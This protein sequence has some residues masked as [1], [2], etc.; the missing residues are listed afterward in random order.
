MPPARIKNGDTYLR[1]MSPYFESRP[2][3]ALIPLAFAP[4]E[5]KT[6]RIEKDGTWRAVRMIEED[7]PLLDR[8][9]HRVAVQIDERPHVGADLVGALEAGLP[10]RRS[11]PPW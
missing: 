2:P 4:F 7:C 6:L 5:I 3:E 9:A 1:Y 10:G 8:D 11:L